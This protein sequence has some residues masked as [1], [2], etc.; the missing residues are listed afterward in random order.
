MKSC[1]RMN[2]FCCLI[3]SMIV[4]CG[5]VSADVADFEDVKPGK[6]PAT[7]FISGGLLFESEF[8]ENGV[9]PPDVIPGAN[10]GTG[11][12]QL[13]VGLK[14]RETYENL[15]TQEAKVPVEV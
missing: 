10:N 12:F 8:F 13:L 15:T 5:N 7:P 6:I 14:M 9:F 2:L 4:V 11:L 3:A 1:F